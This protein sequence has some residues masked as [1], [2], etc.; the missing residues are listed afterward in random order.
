MFIDPAFYLIGDRSEIRLEAS[1]HVKFL[2]DEVVFRGI[3]RVDGRSWLQSAIVPR[4]GGASQSAFV[5][6][7][8]R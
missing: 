7:A 5:A 1:E 3:E 2:S 8:A 4:N 6:L